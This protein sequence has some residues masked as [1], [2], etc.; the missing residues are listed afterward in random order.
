MTAWLMVVVPMCLL[1][2]C[3]VDFITLEYGGKFQFISDS[4]LFWCC[5]TMCA[6]ALMVDYINFKRNV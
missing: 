4:H 2:K 1:A 5:I 3:G 6:Y